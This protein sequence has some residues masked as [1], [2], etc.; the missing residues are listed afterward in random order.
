M[1]MAA[2]NVTKNYKK[3][4]MC[5]KVTTDLRF[6]E[7]MKENIIKYQHFFSSFR[8]NYICDC[9]MGLV[10]TTTEVDIE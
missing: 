9:N 7:T 1:P 10:N 4:S 8:G 2:D 6:A 3:L 5:H